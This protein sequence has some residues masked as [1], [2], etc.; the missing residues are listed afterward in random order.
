MIQI[1]QKNKKTS[2]FIAIIS[3]VILVV[4][5]GLTCFAYVAG[6]GPFAEPD[7]NAIDYSNPTKE[8]QDAGDN[9]KASTV[10]GSKDTSGSDQPTVTPSD[11]GGKSSVG[12]IVVAANKTSSNLEVRAAV[13]YVTSSGTCTLILT[14]PSG[15]FTT[16]SPIQPLSSSSACQTF[17]VPLSSLSSGNWTVEV[18]FENDTVKGSGTWAQPISI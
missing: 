15:T 7:P 17:V 2:T 1:K 5:I 3:A 6:V 8:A 12:V 10:D 16:T 11:N 4:I 13:Q 14:G 9:A 18:T